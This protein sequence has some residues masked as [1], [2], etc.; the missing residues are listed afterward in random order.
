VPCLLLFDDVFG[1]V[2]LTSR[3]QQ[4][5][6]VGREEVLSSFISV[7][8]VGLL[9][10]KLLNG[11]CVALSIEQVAGSMWDAAVA[12]DAQQSASALLEQEVQAAAMRTKMR[13]GPKGLI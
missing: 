4:A 5:M 10:V 1:T 13:T 3:L 8:G 9:P 7:V 11:D 6:N 12:E 2:P